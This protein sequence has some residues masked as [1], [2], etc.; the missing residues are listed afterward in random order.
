MQTIKF[1]AIATVILLAPT[2]VAADVVVSHFE[3]LQQ[4]RISKTD[5]NEH[6]FNSKLSTPALVA[7][8]FEALGKSF[9]LQL[10]PNDRIASGLRSDAAVSDVEVYRGGLANNPQ[11]WARIVV[12][13][14]MPR[15]MIWDGVE[16]YA[17]EAPD[18]SALSIDAPVIYRLADAFVVA[19]TMSCGSDFLS[20]SAATIMKDIGTA[21]KVA[22][23][24][25]P[26][27]VSE[28][29]M[30]AIGDFEF[31]D[32]RGGDSAAFA[33][34]TT[35]LNNVDGYFSEQVGVQINVDLIET[36]SDP[37]DPFG[38]TLVAGDLLGE[39]SEYRLQSASH[40]SRGLT[41]L[42]TG[43]DL[44]TTSVG[45]AWRG[46]L[47]ENYFGA[48]L[49]EGNRGATNDS[50]IAAHEI[51][52]NFG[53]EHDGEIDSSCES[54]TGAFI[55]SPSVSSSA[56]F[57][58]CS[59]TVMQAEAAAAACV[60]ALPAVDVSVRPVGQVSNVL[61]GAATDIEY[62]VA[63]NGT[64]DVAGVLVNISF[65][66]VLAL[67]TVTTSVGTC[68]SGAGVIDCDLG[69]LVGLSSAAITLSVMP[70]VVGA[71]TL[72]ASVSTTDTDER[73][74]NNQD[75]ILLTVD[76]AVDLVASVPTSAVVFIDDST[77]VSV[78]LSNLS[79]IDATNVTA[80]I[81]LENG[82]QAN[83][84]TWS[85]G[86]CDFTAQQV[87]CQA[88]TFAAQTTSV[89]TVNATG[90]TIGRKDV[91]V[92][93]TSTEA[94]ANPNNNSI[95]GEVR[96]TT[97]NAEKDDGGGVTI[98]FVILLGLFSILSARRRQVRTGD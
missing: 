55:M 37:A 15:G 68:S 54:E 76:S 75:S 87:D 24:R 63:S 74:S 1:V 25:A 57:S 81:T 91:T 22:I 78:T 4:T 48:G 30:S 33:A 27:A 36:H 66:N 12:F 79:V 47:C 83:S 51:G 32:A 67:N 44:D 90:V 49:S 64:L 71:G 56:Q 97:P 42:Y 10:V 43:K 38:D 16:M 9:D 3:P 6:S 70:N 46:V 29:T 35:R 14:G 45:I 61:L 19:G 34:I 41:H 92:V 98:P 84:A 86:T 26:G 89:L 82:L 31:T 52:H 8:R 73:P 17:I 11:S 88:G 95:V 20:G 94:E 96:V 2:L 59:I 65:P 77:S 80:S 85:I 39:V 72:A 28:I 5:K 53:A 50:L 60:A 23:A 7:I 62:E 21:T 40:N 58:D 18:D 13:D 93:L 69:D